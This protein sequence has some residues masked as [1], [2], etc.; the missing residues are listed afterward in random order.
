MALHPAG[1]VF[2]IISDRSELCKSSC[3]KSLS[4]PA[5]SLQVPVLEI[6][7]A[8]KAQAGI[9]TSRLSERSAVLEIWEPKL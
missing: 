1:Q 9:P 6:K 3:S 5:S 8:W 4:Y 7:T 2:W